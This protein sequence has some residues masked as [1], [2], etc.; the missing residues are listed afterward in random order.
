MLDAELFAGIDD[1][2]EAAFGTSS[3]VSIPSPPLV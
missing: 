1:L 3:K 2:E